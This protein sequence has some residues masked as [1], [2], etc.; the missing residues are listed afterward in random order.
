M[1]YKYKK[2]SKFISLV[3]RHKPE[4]IGLNLDFEGWASVDELLTKMS[5]TNSEIN[6]DILVDIV[7]TNDKQRFVFNT[8]K[9][10]IR[11][12]QGHSIDIDLGL[13]P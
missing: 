4:T 9:T 1:G 5:I 13:I 7:K 11:A 3:L 12:N 6:F 10:K 8:D 2:I